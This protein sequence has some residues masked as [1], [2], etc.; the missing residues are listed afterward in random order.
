MEREN[1]QFRHDLTLST[2]LQNK[3]F[4]VVAMTRTAEKRTKMKYAR[5]KRAICIGNHMISSAIWN[6]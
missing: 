1:G 2:K 6:K 3:S 4:P 5:A